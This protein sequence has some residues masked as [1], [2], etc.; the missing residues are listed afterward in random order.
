MKEAVWG[1]LAY[2]GPRPMDVLDKA[3]CPTCRLKGARPTSLTAEKYTSW[4][5]D[6]VYD[7]SWFIEPCGCYVSLS[8]WE[9]RGWNMGR[10]GFLASW[11]RV[12]F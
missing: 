8:S 12:G 3:I 1:T 2:D 10:W 9:F 4:G 5:D 11:H 6:K 7:V